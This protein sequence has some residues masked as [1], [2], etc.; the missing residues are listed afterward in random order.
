MRCPECDN[1]IF[2]KVG[3]KTRL[4]V[5]GRIIFDEKGCVAQCYWCKAF[6]KIPLEIM[7]GTPVVAERFF[8]PEKA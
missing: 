5:T 4:R 3:D 1:S 6:V 2:Q 8:L 7:D